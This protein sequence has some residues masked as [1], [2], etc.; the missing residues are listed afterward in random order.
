MYWMVSW[1][2]FK[3]LDLVCGLLWL[4]GNKSGDSSRTISS[5]DDG[6]QHTGKDERSSWTTA[7]V[8]STFSLETSVAAAGS[9]DSFSMIST[10]LETGVDAKSTS[11]SALAID[12]F[13]T[14]ASSSICSQQDYEILKASRLFIYAAWLERHATFDK[15]SA[16]IILLLLDLFGWMPLSILSQKEAMS[17]V[18]FFSVRLWLFSPFIRSSSR[19]TFLPFRTTYSCIITLAYRPWKTD[20]ATPEAK[21]TWSVWCSATTISTTTDYLRRKSCLRYRSLF[22]N[23]I[24]RS[25]HFIQMIPESLTQSS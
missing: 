21:I 20:T 3:S 2:R 18:N 9:A 8:Q 24:V 1:I 15:K 5:E 10:T 19:R 23:E 22:F 16:N 14:P 6:I 4:D 11:Q 25:K 7:T 12:S 17:A 13:L